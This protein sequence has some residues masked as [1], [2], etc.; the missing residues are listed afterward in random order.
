MW[1]NGLQSVLL[2]VVDDAATVES[3]FC[4]KAGLGTNAC[5]VLIENLSLFNL[6]G[7]FHLLNSQLSWRYLLATS[8]SV[9]LFDFTHQHNLTPQ[10]AHLGPAQG[11][12]R[13][14]PTVSSRWHRHGKT[15]PATPPQDKN[16]GTK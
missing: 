2:C 11:C 3:A 10:L 7:G 6:P 14:R 5:N 4:F 16:G 15:C 12:T 13:A 1:R 9:T 8:P